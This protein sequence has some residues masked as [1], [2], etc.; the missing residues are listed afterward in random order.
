MLRYYWE[1]FGAR[2]KKWLAVRVATRW[3]ADRVLGNF[4]WSS[5][6]SSH[7]TRTW[8]ETPAWFSRLRLILLYS[9]PGW[10][11]QL[12]MC[13]FRLLCVFLS[14]LH[15]KPVFCS[16]T[17]STTSVSTDSSFW[18]IP[19][20]ALWCRGHRTTVQRCYLVMR[21]QG[22]R[23]RE[24]MVISYWIRKA[25]HTHA[26]NSDTLSERKKRKMK[27]REIIRVKRIQIRAVPP[28]RRRDRQFKT[29][30]ETNHYPGINR[31]HNQE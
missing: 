22:S 23:Q 29:H 9:V 1:R 8:Y 6:A 21:Q 4:A 14:I 11:R 30:N 17:S 19:V 13:C 5:T 10:P 15:I 16:S 24:A 18:D 27:T 20:Q 2:K 28:G 3:V 12:L 31:N 25:Q 7:V 26:S